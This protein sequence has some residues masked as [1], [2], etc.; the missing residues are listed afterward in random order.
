MNK[1]FLK[2]ALAIPTYLNKQE[3]LHTAISLQADMDMPEPSINFSAYS[4]FI[5]SS[6]SPVL[7]H[8][9][10]DKLMSDE[11]TYLSTN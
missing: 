5:S 1:S 11:K 7:K 4:L 2:A 3:S 6:F 8:T 10:S 9:S